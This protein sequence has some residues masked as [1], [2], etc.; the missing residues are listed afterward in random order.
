MQKPAGVQ[1]VF[2]RMEVANDAADFMAG[3]PFAVAK[4][5]WIQ[6]GRRSR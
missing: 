2:L 4:I 3:E 5:C 6:I 1:P